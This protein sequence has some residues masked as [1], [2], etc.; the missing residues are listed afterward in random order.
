MTLQLI[1]CL[2]ARRIDYFCISGYL[3]NV[4]GISTQTANADLSSDTVPEKNRSSQNTINVPNGSFRIQTTI[5]ST[6]NQ[7]PKANCCLRN[8]GMDSINVAYM[9]EVKMSMYVWMKTLNECIF[10]DLATTYMNE[11]EIKSFY[12]APVTK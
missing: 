2:R 8:V 6:E 1:P 5:P 12:L 4:Q 11:E 3:E 9:K 7:E 10:G